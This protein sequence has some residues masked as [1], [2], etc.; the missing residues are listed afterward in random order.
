MASNKVYPGELLMNDINALLQRADKLKVELEQYQ[1]LHSD[2]ILEALYI[3]YTYDSNRIEGNTLTLRETD[4]S[5][6]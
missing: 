1:G 6:P 3:E 2:E 4:T 5:Y